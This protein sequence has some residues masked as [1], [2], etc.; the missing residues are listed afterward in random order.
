MVIMVQLAC[1]YIFDSNPNV[2]KMVHGLID[3]CNSRLLS[4]L[5]IV[6]NIYFI[7]ARL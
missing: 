1:L 6:L 3:L 7:M 5:H 2:K 4:Q